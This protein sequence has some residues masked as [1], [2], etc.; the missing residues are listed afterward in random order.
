MVQ[1]TRRGFTLVELL[2]VIAIIAV[3]IG[4]L[5]PAVQ[6]V[7]EA[8][9]R[10]SCL[11]NL[12]QLGLSLHS[13]HGANGTFPPAF[14]LGGTDVIHDGEATGFTYLLPYL[15]QDNTYKLYDMN[16]LWYS[17]ANWTAVGVPIKL[18]RCPSNSAA[19]PVLDLSPWPGEG[20]PPV[21]GINDYAFCRGAN[22]TLYWDFNQI[23]LQVRG[24]FNIEREGVTSAGVRLTDI[25]DGTST[26]LAMGDAA[27][28]S[29]FFP[30]RDVTTGNVVPGALLLQSWSAANVGD[31]EGAYNG[32]YFGSVF[33][34]TA[35]YGLQPNP[36]DEPMNRRP[37]TPTMRGTDTGSNSS[38]PPDYIS[39]FR[40]MHTGGCNFLFCDGS[41]RFITQSIDAATYRAL[42]TYAGR[43]V[44]S[45]GSF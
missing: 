11:N 13:Y 3:L 18:F 27:A 35:Q 22:G 29:T 45:G 33:A 12:K 26:T 43:E 20:L 41:V 17:P 37:A 2:V 4:L 34:V 9:A 42:S 40:S 39:G 25:V 23:P 14:R 32:R 19:N 36:V 1:R 38:D 8:S 16:Q 31:S 24:V 21:V 28:G 30:V 6:K 44:L 5:L 7:R 15:E 10:A